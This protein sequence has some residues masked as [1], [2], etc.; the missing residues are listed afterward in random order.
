[1]SQSNTKNYPYTSFNFIIEIDNVE[2]GGF[3]ELTGLN[4][5]TETEEITEGGINT[6]AHKLPKRSKYGNLTLK[7]GMTNSIDLYQ[8]YMD[9]VKGNIAQKEIGIVLR[10]EKNQDTDRWQFKNAFPVKWIGPELNASSNNVAF[11][12]VE[13]AHSGLSN[14]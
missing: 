2:S 9:I 5:E 11:E 1:M 12:S 8:W 7:R 4:I 10:N 6:F 3:S 14:I 13:I